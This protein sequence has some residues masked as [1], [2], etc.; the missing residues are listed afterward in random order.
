MC[1]K[2]YSLRRG[3]DTLFLAVGT[4]S[5]LRQQ[6]R[7]QMER[8]AFYD[9]L[10]EL[11]N[12]R[13]FR[14]RLKQAIDAARRKG[15]RVA[16][17]FLDLDRFKRVNDSLGHE[18]G[19]ELLRQAAAR[20]GTCVRAQD[21]V[22]RLGGD[23]FTVLL[24]E[25]SDAAAAGIVAA[26]ISEVLRQPIVLGGNE[27][28][29]TSSI[30]IA[31]APDDSCD[32]TGLLHHADRAMYRAKEKGRNNFRY[33]TEELNQL[34]SRQLLLETELRATVAERGFLIHFQPEHTPDGAA[35]AGLEAL[36]RWPHPTRGL[37]FAEEFLGI[38]EHTG[39]ILELTGWVLRQ[40][41]E[42]ASRVARRERPLPVSVNLSVRQF[43]Q[44][45]LPAL[46]ETALRETGL[47]PDLLR[48]EF[49][50]R[51]LMDDLE[52]TLSTLQMLKRLGVGL[53]VDD[54]GVGYSSLVHLSRLPVDAIKIDKT[55]IRD[56]PDDRSS[57]AATAAIIS[58]AHKLGLNA[59]AE[60]VETE[61]QLDFL[62]ESACDR[63]QGYF[64]SI[65]TDE[66][67]LDYL[68]KMTR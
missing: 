9:S 42:A 18:A 61:E 29:I 50:E 25:I 68:M 4:E 45:S 10:T 21:T 54:F 46:V 55:L 48:L 40:A 23:E 12:R 63:V 17:M 34:V 37:L 67:G 19:D 8:L 11:P 30:G 47:A 6:S 5:P 60:G 43:H 15:G 52:L 7:Q 53:C 35:M 3:P 14:D 33:F 20:I 28:R 59:I 32:V 26:K 56:T 62:R 1:W 58:M 65:P 39:L 13:L 24:P 49:S 22:A 51:L 41:C 31:I 27:V 38:L 64:C 16:V 57:A 36:L 44:V 2:L 66:D